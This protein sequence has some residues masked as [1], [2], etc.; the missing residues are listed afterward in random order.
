MRESSTYRA[1]VEEGRREGIIEGRMDAARRILLRQG[2]KRFGE[3]DAAAV[4]AME[5]IK[6]IGRL[7]AMVDRIIDGEIHAWDDLLRTP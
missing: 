4:A 7:E 6:D 1:I 2:T 3:P 5:A